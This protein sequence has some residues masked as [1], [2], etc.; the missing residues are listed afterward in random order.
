MD[1]PPTSKKIPSVSFSYIKA[2]ATPAAG[3]ERMVRMGRLRTSSTVM[4]PPSQ[5]ITISGL[6]MPAPWMLRSVIV[7]ASSIFGMMLAFT[8]AVRVRIFRP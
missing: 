7:A 8:T 5:R 4:T 3:P 6:L 1:V 2:P